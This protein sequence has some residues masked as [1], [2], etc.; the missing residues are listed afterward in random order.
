MLST[1]TESGPDTVIEDWYVG[2]AG[3][4]S[5][6][7]NHWT[8]K[9]IY[10][11]AVTELLDVRPDHPLTWKSIVGAARPR[12]CRST[13]Y[14]VAGSQARRGMVDHLIEDGSITSYTIALH[15]RTGDPVVQLVDETKVWSFWPYRQRF[16]PDAAGGDAEQVP[17]QLR[18]LLTEWAC[19]H[20]GLAAANCCR[21]PAC[22]V[23]DLT[24]LSAGRLAPTRAEARVAEVLRQAIGR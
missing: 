14:E 20:P 15:Y 4:R 1:K 21:P 23:E 10:Y 11:R 18:A 22:T 24:L 8:T 13:F 9:V 6:R 12:G 5:A 16:R 7:R 2:L 17:E 19:A 3:N